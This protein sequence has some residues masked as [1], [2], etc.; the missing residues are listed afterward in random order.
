[1]HQMPPEGSTIEFKNVKYEERVPFV[2]YADFECLTTPISND[3]DSEDTGSDDDDGE[4]EHTSEQAEDGATRKL[5]KRIPK[6]VYQEHKPISVGIKL[7][8][9]VPGILDKIPYETHTGTDVTE[10]LLQRLLG[11]QE[12]CVKF[13]FDEKR[14]IF[15]ANDCAAHVAARTCY[16]CEKPFDISGKKG[17]QKVRDHDHV[18]GAY[19]GAAHS[20]CNLLKRR[21]RK[22]PVFFHNFRGY[23]SHLI[24]S[25]LGT[26]K[27]QKLS[28]IAQTMEKYLQLQFGDH[29]VYK[30]SLQFL[31]CSLE[32]LT[33][34][35][36]SSGREYFVN[37][38]DGFKARSDAN[39]DL[40]L[41]KGVYP[42][43]YM[44]GEA[45]LQETKLP[46]REAFFSRLRQEECST[47][48]YAHAQQVW[49]DFGCST[50][51]EYHDLYLKCDVLQLADVFEA[52][53]SMS[54]REYGLDP[55]HYVSAPHLSWDAMLRTTR[56][57]LDLLSDD[58]MFTMI[59]QN[60]RGGVAMISKRHGKANNKYMKEHYDPTKPSKYLMYVDANNLYG[61]SM[62]QP[63][64]T[65]DFEWMSE[66]E[67]T[68]IDW[69]G[70]ASDQDIGYIVEC[71]L[72]YPDRLHDSH[73][74]Y[75]LAP[76]RIAVETEMLS[77]TQ[78][79]QQAIYC[80]KAGSTKF[81]KLIPNLFAK[82]NYACHY[83]N[84]QYYLD[85]GIEL[86]KVH[87]VIRFKQSAWLANYIS[88]NS[89]LRA[90]ARNDFEKD[91]FK[92]MNNAVYGKTC[93]NVLKRQNIE[94]VTDAK[95]AKKLIDKPHCIGFRIFT[96][97]IAAI[98]MQKLTSAIDKPTYVGL[99]VLEYAKLH[100][101]S[102]I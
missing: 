44:D 19:R 88:K 50:I 75:P 11:Y 26:H 52:F 82:R 42:Y 33:Q 61:W 27:D 78:H 95:R 59:Q 16:I 36:L 47:E 91:F 32:R 76:E 22:I 37:M 58:A 29:L 17:D 25:A 57:K 100:M 70:Q 41:R 64:P 93:E 83:M 89:Q 54:M 39:I 94:L 43:D 62:S 69:R 96:Q 65:G 67:W 79:E 68:N 45:K 9:A 12:M 90:K 87:R 48:N 80:G 2:I 84:L 4:D 102:R 20:S 23:D 21:Q 3:K 40:L 30:D 63:L 28:V 77:D 86:T 18:S 98:A 7:V 6:G 71:D 55:A 15:T 97:N 14:M 35:L 60:L 51:R 10:W 56:C 5:K 72:D 38:L 13:L 1:M 73:S 99:A 66:S 34:N 8:S 92:L 31:S 101:Y 24:V 74:D 53:R 81:N 49:H 85:H 46:D